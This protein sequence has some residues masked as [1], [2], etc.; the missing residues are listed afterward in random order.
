MAEISLIIDDK[1]VK[2]EAGK[3]VLQAALEADIYIPTLCSHPDLP[4]FTSVKPSEFIYQGENKIVSDE[5][6]EYEGGC[7]LCMVQIEGNDNL[8]FACRTEATEGMTIKTGSPEIQAAREENLAVILADHPHAC[9][10]CAQREGCTREP[11]SSN[12][13]VKERCCPRL[14]NCELQ[15]VAN[16][17]GIAEDTPR[18]IHK[19]LPIL[20]EDPLYNR[21]FNLCIGCLRCVR[22]C[23]LLRGC[24]VLG[25]AVNSGKVAVGTKKAPYL[26]DADCSFCGACIEV[27]PTGALTD[28]IKI[29][30]ANRE[31]S[32]VP[33]KHTCPAGIDVPRYIRLIS[34]GKYDEAVAVV[35]EK[36]PFPGVL[37]YVCYHPCETVCRRG[38]VNQ[39]VSICALK[40]FAAIND[41]K[42]W[43]D[44]IKIASPTG[45]KVAIIGSGPAGLTAAYYLAK[46]GH[47]ITVFEGLSEAGGMM[48]VGMSGKTLPADILDEEIKTISDLGVNIKTNSKIESIDELFEQ[49]FDAIFV[50]TGAPHKKFNKVLLQ[51]PDILKGLQEGEGYFITA[52]NES[53]ATDKK[54]IF[55]GGDIVRGPALVKKRR[56]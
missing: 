1:E 31:K 15:K 41:E 27:C 37:G 3:T 17:I 51:H 34:E 35:R 22:A 49:G 13:D 43:K 54:G 21:D 56:A 36:V 28:K 4:N 10:T 14:G 45:K 16:F 39:A 5:V 55:A 25:Y 42:S 32:F 11:C 9:L 23:N 33:C 19:N 46:L 26:A 2:T 6:S 38:D 53:L 18:F 12:V 44:K 20:K 30:E 24:E 7:M 52:D 40:G 8:S 50:A 48:R 29:S 47:Q